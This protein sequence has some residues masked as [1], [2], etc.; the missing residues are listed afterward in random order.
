MG[1]FAHTVPVERQARCAGRAPRL[2]PLPG[3]RRVAK[4]AGG[5]QG[6]CPGGRHAAAT[7]GASPR[8]AGG[9]DRAGAAGATV[10]A[11]ARC[12]A[13]WRARPAGGGRQTAIVRACGARPRRHLPPLGNNPRRR[14]HLVPRAPD[15]AR[16]PMSASRPGIA[17]AGSGRADMRRPTLIAVPLRWL[18]LL[19]GCTSQRTDRS[20]A[21]LR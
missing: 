18:A 7:N 14:S 4:P 16:P 15:A 11:P 8:R 13:K 6:S 9:G 2:G 17:K 3:G 5:V 21:P 12:H 20:A 1:G 19:V 10:P